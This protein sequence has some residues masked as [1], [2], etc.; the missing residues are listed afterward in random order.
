[1]MLYDLVICFSFGC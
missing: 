1:M